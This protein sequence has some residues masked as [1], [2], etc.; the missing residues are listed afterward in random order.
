MSLF[1]DQL[2]NRARWRE[3]QVIDAGMVRDSY[4]SWMKRKLERSLYKEVIAA[5]SQ[6]CRISLVFLPESLL[7]PLASVILFAACSV[8][9]PLCATSEM[10][11]DIKIVSLLCLYSL[12]TYSFISRHL[13]NESALI[14]RG[15]QI[16]TWRAFRSL[17]SKSS[18]A[19]RLLLIIAYYI[20]TNYAI[21]LSKAIILI[22]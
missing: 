16:L 7:I 8:A 22:A 20:L 14:V 21:F 17:S 13:I 12:W 19:V 5:S 1:I 11:T 2:T 3:I 4:T 10:I 9:S 18:R 6:F 15:T